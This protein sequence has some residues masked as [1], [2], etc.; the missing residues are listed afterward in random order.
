MKRDIYKPCRF[1]VETARFRHRHWNQL[2]TYPYEPGGVIETYS[3]DMTRMAVMDRKDIFA[4]VQM[5]RR[6][7][8]YNP[9]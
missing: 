9:A 6:V 7:R 3:R 1:R 5:S 2:P 8:V 4:K